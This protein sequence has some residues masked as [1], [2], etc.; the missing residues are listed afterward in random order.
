VLALRAFDLAIQP[1]FAFQ[2]SQFDSQLLPSQ[3]ILKYFFRK[4]ITLF[5]MSG[6]QV[7]VA[8][9]RKGGSLKFD[10]DYYLKTHMPL[11]AKT[12]KKHG[13]KS[14]VVTEFQEDNDY[15]FAVVM[16]FESAE[17]WGTAYADADTKAVME[18]IP[19]FSNEG[20]VLIHGSVLTRESV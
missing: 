7:I 10:K 4:P 6:Y 20:P 5:N 8:Y 17:G 12:W 14:Y 19:N 2:V 3:F 9:P 15:G 13:F 16:E 1:L 18:D 11:V